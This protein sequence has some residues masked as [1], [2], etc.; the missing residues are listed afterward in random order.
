MEHVKMSYSYTSNEAWDKI[1]SW[2][3]LDY[4]NNY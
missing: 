1:A 2:V 4:Y 3:L